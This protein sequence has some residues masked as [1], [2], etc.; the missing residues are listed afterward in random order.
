MK[1]AFIPYVQGRNDYTDG[2]HL[3]YG[4]AIHNT[5]NDASDEAEASYATRRTDGVSSHFYADAD[6]VT[7]S[8]DTADK[9]GHAG[10]ANGNENAVCVEI[11]G[12][13]GKSREWWLANVAWDLLG[14]VLAAVIRAHWPDGS[15]QVRR[16]S[17]AEM[18]ATPKVRA[19]Y[20]H[21]DMR[22][23]WGGTTHTDPGPGFPWD[24]LFAAVNAA[25]GAG[26]GTDMYCKY[27]DKGSL[28]VET[29]QRR[30]VRLGAT[31]KDG[32]PFTAAD[33]DRSYGDDV[34][35]GVISIIGGPGTNFGPLEVE[36]FEYAYAV[37]FGP[38]GDKG[39]K[40]DP[41]APGPKGDTG[42]AG[43]DAVILPGT[44]LVV[45]SAA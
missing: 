1:V 29:L 31:R 22:L 9:V 25:L 27:G 40:G 10:S 6:S 8:V 20:G 35:A 19:F 26:E 33:V 3:K 23:A 30:L 39:D 37:R 32:K 7:Q 16:A 42:A 38:K 14:Q 18:K 36:A 21:D 2:D 44:R 11:T 5:S 41:G 34:K 28:N 45:E 43:A 15:F 24:R 4:I 13:N 12:S 17:V